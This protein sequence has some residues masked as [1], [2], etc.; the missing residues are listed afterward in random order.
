[1]G[2]P[3][4][5]AGARRP[6][7]A[8]GTSRGQALWAGPRSRRSGRG[9]RQRA[10]VSRRLAAALGAVGRVRLGAGP[11]LSTLGWGTPK[12]PLVPQP[13]FP[14]T[15][16]P[17]PPPAQRRQAALG[18]GHPPPPL[19][20][21]L[22]PSR[23]G[24]SG[25]AQQV[26]AVCLPRP[27]VP[28]ACLPAGFRTALD[29]DRAAGGHTGGEHGPAGA[30]GCTELRGGERPA[31]L[32]SGREPPPRDVLGRALG[33]GGPSGAKA[34]RW[35]R[36]GS[37]VMGGTVSGGGGRRWAGPGP[38][39]SGAFRQ[40]GGGVQAGSSVSGQGHSER[41]GGV[42]SNGIL[43]NSLATTWRRAVGARPGQGWG[44]RSAGR[45]Q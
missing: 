6:G 19:P 10:R 5:G 15:P 4:Q 36:G 20:R 2:R 31:G 13:C 3:V 29:R 25:C 27:S 16:P 38:V 43:Q 17:R 33:A 30:R 21:S 9:P 11:G 32:S 12:Q 42:V 18:R 34:L 23:A 37:Q 39:A 22:G 41:G 7:K 26:R 14:V 40:R 44:C 45:A 28:R 1:M 35:E 24:A 8:Q